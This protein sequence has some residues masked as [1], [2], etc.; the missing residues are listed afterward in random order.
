MNL[1]KDHIDQ[2]IVAYLVAWPSNGCIST[3]DRD[4]LREASTTYISVFDVLRFTR[5]SSE[6]EL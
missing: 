2:F 6:N 4:E 5:D 1:H 3:G